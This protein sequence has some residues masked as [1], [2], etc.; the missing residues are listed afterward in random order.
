MIGQEKLIRMLEG[1]LAA[2]QADQTEILYVGN[3]LGLTRFANSIIHQ[4]VAEK[5]CRI[6]FR[7]VVAKR[8]GVASCNSFVL[9]DLKKSLADS[10]VIA[11]HRPENPHFP[12]LPKPA[13]YKEIN[14]WDDVTAAFTPSARARAVRKMIG[15]ATRK[16]FT[17]AGALST[18]SGEIAVVNSLGVRAYQPLTTASTN[19]VVMSD[20][21]SGY[22]SDTSRR[23]SDIDFDHLA[24]TA[25]EKCNRS[26]NPQTIAPGEYEVLLEPAAVAEVLEWLSYVGFGS[27]PF[28][29]GTSFLSGRIGKKVT[30]DKITIYDNALDDRTVAFPFDFEGVPKK[31]VPF[32]DKGVARGVVH[33]SASAVKSRTKS[34]GHAMAPTESDKGAF[35]LNI[36]MEHGKAPRDKMVSSIKRG[37][38]V[39]RFHYING[40]IDTRNAVLTGMTRDGTFWVE[41]GEIVHGLKNLRFTDSIT[42][43]FK[44]TVAISLETERVG[45]WWSDVGCMT[46]PAIH[47]GSFR[48]SGKTEF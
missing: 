9:A 16:S 43:A 37:I 1:V 17:A 15:R 34:T 4:N 21:S 3:E 42:R 13:R 29:Q 31:K 12:G 20:T 6:F 39:T 8:V 45:S 48:F 2:S 19:V 38:L 28:Q 46:V 23:V 22:A 40:F 41:N 32:I 10:L 44:S 14:T 27:K 25:V 47:L 30:S 26:Q 36:F 35:G 18:A 11:R 5:N 7:S 33:D 24:R